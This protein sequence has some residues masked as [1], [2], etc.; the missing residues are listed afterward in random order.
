MNGCQNW[1]EKIALAAGG[2]LRDND[3]ERHL[4]DCPQCAATLA[5]LRESLALLQE[6]HAGPIGEAHYA[7]VRA[8]VL[9]RIDTRRNRRWLW[10]PAVLAATAVVAILLW[11]TSPPVP[12]PP[13][14]AIAAPPAPT[15]PNTPAPHNPVNLHRHIRAATV[16]ERPVARTAPAPT[17]P[18]LVKFVTDD[19]NV[20]IY[21]IGDSQESITPNPV[22]ESRY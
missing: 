3:R 19:P 22:S 4:S 1:E 18:V 2:D 14:V 15:L 8:R 10:A 16:R 11:P 13:F 9:S 5:A 21:W 6:A 7:A 20:V 12:P 17:A